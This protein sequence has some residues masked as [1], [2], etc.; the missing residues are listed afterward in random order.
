M[1]AASHSPLQSPDTDAP[2]DVSSLE[3]LM[4]DPRDSAAAIRF[5]RSLTCR[6]L[7]AA[8]DFYSPFINGCGRCAPGGATG[9]LW[10]EGTGVW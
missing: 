5:A 8:E 2:S 4:N 10:H 9:L 1:S 7:M 3:A 6:E